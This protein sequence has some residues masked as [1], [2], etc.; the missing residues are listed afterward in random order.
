M[1][2]NL[3]G[4]AA[5]GVLLTVGFTSAANAN[6]KPGQ[7]DLGGVQQICLVDDGT[8]YSPTF[9]HWRGRWQTRDDDEKA[10][11]FGHFDDEIGDV[12]EDSMIFRKGVL[13]W[14]EWESQ[15]AYYDFYD[16][17]A[18]TRVQKTCDPESPP[19]GRL[20]GHKTPMR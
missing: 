20:P 8:W 1:N 6:L 14:T 7:Y 2:V 5:L 19:R 3:L 10:I 16:D 11:I 12:G 18:I 13:D 9:Y 17:V 15:F 4:P